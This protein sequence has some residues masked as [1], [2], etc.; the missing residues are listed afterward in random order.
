[1]EAM[2]ATEAEPT[3]AFISRDISFMPMPNDVVFDRKLIKWGTGY[4]LR[5][6]A[7]EV[8]QL[9]LKV[10]EHVHARVSPPQTVNDLSVFNKFDFGPWPTGKTV[11]DLIDEEID[12]M[13][14]LRK[15]A[16]KPGGV[17]HAGR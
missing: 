13:Y 4:G 1:M 6:T 10:G 11:Q 7:K 16:S 2:S 15:L 17:K 9:G 8:E 3:P 12:E 5:L 14:G